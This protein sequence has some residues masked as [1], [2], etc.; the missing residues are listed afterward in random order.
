M[1]Q[2][3]AWPVVIVPISLC[4]LCVRE[5]GGEIGCE[6]GKAGGG[7]TEMMGERWK[8]RKKIGNYVRHGG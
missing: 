4:L 3:V 8:R 6:G 1:L 5:R 7:G 2:S